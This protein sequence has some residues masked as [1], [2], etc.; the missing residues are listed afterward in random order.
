MQSIQKYWKA[1]GGARAF[2]ASAYLR[3]SVLLTVL[4]FTFIP[5]TSDSLQFLLFASLQSA[6]SLLGFT[7][8]CIF[9]LMVMDRRFLDKL[10][11]RM[12]DEP[13]GMPS[14]FLVVAASFT[15]FACVQAFVLL[16]AFVGKILIIQ[17]DI[18]FAFSMW[19]ILYGILLIFAAIGA[20]FKLTQWYDAMVDDINI[21]KQTENIF[22]EKTCFKDLAE[23]D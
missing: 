19:L 5:R 23:D 4:L 3:F 10:K 18:Y 1:Y 22:N 14:P 8:L 9:L 2:F 20:I 12:P 21:S 15:H 16:N 7:L 17:R 13:A 6:P 11:S